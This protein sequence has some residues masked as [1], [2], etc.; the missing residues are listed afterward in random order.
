MGPMEPR[1]WLKK[2]PDLG[3]SHIA[4]TNINNTCD[5]WDFV[6]FCQQNQI[7]PVV[8]SEIRNGNEIC[9]ILLARNNEGFEQINRFISKHLQE[10]KP[11]PKRPDLT[12]VYCIFPFGSMAVN[13]LQVTRIYRST[14]IRYQ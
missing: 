14:N 3:I 4:L 6:D 1:N 10:E 7:K 9:Y 11:F 13:E 5:S 8:G 12:D 2:L